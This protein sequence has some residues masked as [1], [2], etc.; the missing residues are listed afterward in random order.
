MSVPALSLKLCDLG[1]CVIFFTYELERMIPN[2]LEYGKERHTL[3]CYHML[4]YQFS[5]VPEQAYSS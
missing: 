4:R 5:G 2:P 1:C 3:N